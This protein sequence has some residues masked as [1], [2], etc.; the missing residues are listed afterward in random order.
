MVLP[1]LMVAFVLIA[2]MVA[3]LVQ[4]MAAADEA[5]TE[6]Q[7]AQIRAYWAMSG[8]VDYRLSRGHQAFSSTNNVTDTLRI[9]TLDG[10]ANTASVDTLTYV[11]TVPQVVF[12][13]STVLT[14]VDV[15]G[16]VDGHYSM[17][18]SLNAQTP[19]DVA[20]PLRGLENRVVDLVVDVCSG[21]TA[22]VARSQTITD[23]ESTTLL[24]GTE[25]HGIS[26]IHAYR[27]LPP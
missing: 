26:T 6:E 11:A 22:R 15:A 16:G 4:H 17:R 20:P 3:S 10:F 23:C 12:S 5:G 8:V 25:D 7:L 24:S 9:S 14:D 27:R 21:N 19:A 13:V 18:V 2:I 1:M